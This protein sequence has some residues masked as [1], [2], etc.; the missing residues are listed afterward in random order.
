MIAN[1]RS[2]VRPIVLFAGVL[3]LC[4]HLAQAD[5]PMVDYAVNGG[6]ER[7]TSVST[8]CREQFA[9]RSVTVGEMLPQSWQLL[10]G[11]TKDADV[12]LVEGKDAH[13][14][15]RA[16]R[17][18]RGGAAPRIGSFGLL[19][20]S[21]LRLSFWISGEGGA[22]VAVGEHYRVGSKTR[23]SVLSAPKKPGRTDW[24]QVQGTVTLNP[25][26]RTFS[27]TFH[28][29]GDVIVDDI[30]LFAPAGTLTPSPV[31]DH[32]AKSDE[33]TLF[34]LDFDDGLPADVKVA[35][36]PETVP[37]R[38]RKAMH[39]PAESALHVS[40]KG[41]IGRQQGTVECWVKP[42]FEGNDR[43]D[44]SFL[45]FGRMT[46][47]L[48]RRTKYNHVLFFG[49][50]HWQT[51][52]AVMSPFWQYAA[53]WG[54]GQWHHVAATWSDQTWQLFV[55]GILVSIAPKIPEERKVKVNTSY[56]K[57][58]PP[59]FDTDLVIGSEGLALD[60]IRVSDV[61]RYGFPP[62]AAQTTAAGTALKAVNEEGEPDL[63]PWQPDL[64]RG[65]AAAV[66][67]NLDWVFEDADSDASAEERLPDGRPLLRLRDATDM[68]AWQA[69]DIDSGKYILGIITD[70]PGQV[71]LN[72]VPIPF[73]SG[74][75]A[76]LVANGDAV[77]EWRTATALD[78]HPADEL[79]FNGK[80]VLV[81]VNLY[82]NAPPRGICNANRRRSHVPD[83]FRLTATVESKDGR[84]TGE[85]SVRNLIG[86][87]TDAAIHARLVDYEQRTLRE[88]TQTVPLRNHASCR[89][90]FAE[91]PTGA[92]L[93][94]LY[95]EVTGP[96]GAYQRHVA[97]CLADVPDGSRPLQ[98]LNGAWPL[99]C[100]KGNPKRLDY[101]AERVP[102][103]RSA[104][105]PG[106]WL[107]KQENSQRVG[108]YRRLFSIPEAMSGGR[109][110]LRFESVNF[111]AHVYVNGQ[112]VG[113][114]TGAWVPFEADIT[115]A[116]V[117]GDNVLEVGVRDVIAAMPP[118]L[119]A[120]MK[121]FDSVDH[122]RLDWPAGTWSPAHRN[123]AGISGFVS[124]QGRSPT[125]TRDI[126]VLSSFGQKRLTVRLTVRNT[127]GAR[128]LIVWQTVEHDGREVLRLPQAD[129]SCPPNGDTRLET[130]CAW[131]E[132]VLWQM[133]QPRLCVLVTQLREHGRVVDEARTRFGF[134][135][136]WVD[137]ARL[138]L[139]GTPQKLRFAHTVSTW[140][141][142][143]TFR[144][145]Y[146]GIGTYPI[147]CLDV[148]KHYGNANAYRLDPLQIALDFG[149]EIG[150]VT[151]CRTTNVWKTAAGKLLNDTYW[152]NA[153][154]NAREAVRAHGNHP[155]VAFW[156][157]SNEF[158]CFSR[159]TDLKDGEALAVRRL[160]RL[161]AVVHEERP[162]SLVESDS[163]GDLHGHADIWSLHYPLDHFPD[164]KMDGH[165]YVFPDCSY[166][167]PLS[168]MFEPEEIIP[169]GDRT[170]AQCP[171]RY[172]Y[173]NI[174]YGLKPIGA[175]ETCWTHQWK[176]A[177]GSC[178]VGGE[179]VFEDDV[180]CRRF[181]FNPATTFQMEGYRDLEMVY[182]YPWRHYFGWVTHQSIPP[183]AA[184]MPFKDTAFIS[185]SPAT[186]TF[187][188]HND[189]ET[190]RVLT[191][192]VAFQTA[193]GEHQM[194][195]VSRRV[196]PAG[197]V[198]L[199]LTPKVPEVERMTRGMLSICM[200]EGTKTH[201]ME[202]VPATVWPSLPQVDRKLNHT[203]LFDPGG[204][205][206]PAL[207][208]VS[209]DLSSCPGLPP[210]N[211]RGLV[212]APQ[213]LPAFLNAVSVT[214]LKRRVEAGLKVVI[215]RHNKYPR[216]LLPVDATPETIRWSGITFA[217]ALGHP[218]LNGV[219][220]DDLR[221]WGR[222]HIVSKADLSLPEKGSFRVIVD[223][224]SGSGLDRAPL[225]EAYLGA[226][227]FVLCQMLLIEKA[228]SHPVAARL[229][230]NLLAY[231]NS[232]AVSQR[233]TPCAVL[234]PGGSQLAEHLVA[235]GVKAE[236]LVWQ[237]PVADLPA[238]V[239]VDAGFPLPGAWQTRIAA[240]LR[241]GGTILASRVTPDTK[242]DWEA[243]SGHALA[244]NTRN[245]EEYHG[246]AVK[247]RA[248]ASLLQ[249][250][251]NW[252]LCWR[253]AIKTAGSVF[254]ASSGTILA[255]LKWACRPAEPHLDS[256]VLLEPAALVDLPCSKGRLVI[257][258]LQWMANAGAA[259]ELANRLASM[260]L[261]N[262][263]V[264]IPPASPI[265]KMPDKVR[266]KPLS[267]AEFANRSL[268]D[269]KER[270]GKGGWSDQGAKFDMRY[271][272]TGRMVTKGVPFDIAPHPHCCV[273]LRTDEYPKE[274]VIGLDCAVA[275]ICLLHSGAWYGGRLHLASFLMEYVDGKSLEV[276]IVGERNVR[277]WA[278]TDLGPLP[279]RRQRAW[280]GWSGR[281]DGF[282]NASVYVLE[283]VNPRPQAVLKAIRFVAHSG[284]V[285]I[286]LAVTL[287]L[288]PKA[289]EPALQPKYM[290]EN[291]RKRIAA[292][293]E[294][295]QTKS[296]GEA[297]ET[298]LADAP[299]KVDARKVLAQI[300][301]DAGELEK[302]R[303]Q[304]LQALK[305]SGESVEIL[306]LLGELNHGRKA[307]RKAL[308]FYRRS[309]A[310]EWNQPTTIRA[311]ETLEELLSNQDDE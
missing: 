179:R 142:L 19:K 41:R 217:R 195:R 43:K 223:S 286:L 135:D 232:A 99:A 125:Y 121:P 29:V 257:D 79:R 59:G 248:D 12:A 131:P 7:V 81:G 196:G 288:P 161:H 190:T 201:H 107:L 20:P 184:V 239:L 31:L 301:W 97:T 173:G 244:V 186:R 149:D 220:G 132:P 157:A 225:L 164:Q 287:A 194:A 9:E 30:Q 80:R 92:H 300:L 254:G 113:E 280:I 263:G 188:L 112:K 136:W 309:L 176:G 218:V 51:T 219:A 127:S 27:L 45:S 229:L 181:G 4:V 289:P 262:L 55:D 305:Y 168:R 224:G 2:Y 290:T 87:D 182:L 297:L 8:R 117:P 283:W 303:V 276:P 158:A 104:T 167:R 222:D 137:G 33:N 238:V 140:H 284:R 63:D 242:S 145:D 21:P 275:G 250:I 260:L 105:V 205:C 227:S 118:D 215:L 292:L 230:T 38:F 102:F 37:G 75:D 258:Q 208:G 147:V 14:G 17:V 198:R 73:D 3:P 281:S 302:A 172:G 261:T 255:P 278:S 61:V 183:I 47:F 153:E 178:T 163:D 57:S 90:T 143:N 116:A 28:L 82:R 245:V 247:R 274:A 174:P 234:A 253:R 26:T 180:A 169:V 193:A 269:E 71:F 68:A 111:E 67:A 24:E 291:E 42:D 152:K 170:A 84:I 252:V 185:G 249:G 23:H 199:E 44:H 162:G 46:G 166:W 78:L 141:Y 64:P 34:L 101:A 272:P 235:L 15:N 93:Y 18:K 285:P 110:L 151:R 294:A 216:N 298:L 62:S 265:L 133:E 119:V 91:A 1:M 279:A 96:D 144:L 89:D 177:H 6:F 241:D 129:L 10:P 299:D 77:R 233:F 22:S 192:R 246:R 211:A 240:H 165:S 32:P 74:G 109:V 98:W 156:E 264:Y 85:F 270:D 54:P 148:A 70:Q 282:P 221:F 154:G 296:A 124:L 266:Y 13:S 139:N 231:A 271:L 259:S 126:R 310:A 203:Y 94:R 72:G 311:I 100:Q 226:G 307:Y 306:N 277:D 120:K 189:T 268:V 39:F 130:D 146:R 200:Q 35:G 16:L 88:W 204:V 206:A 251:S 273:V 60:D 108:W 36:N 65:D 171:S 76:Y 122:N 5:A 197:L 150:V 159:Y 115:E 52:G 106:Y 236:P 69:R 293:V 50:S 256:R 212:I 243:I 308:A 207:R 114:H 66:D 86:R 202:N 11:F 58:L 160:A 134:A 228:S 155:S 295:N 40:L 49:R 103:K 209:A 123:K 53:N 210:K 214:A 48:L 25:S 187:N 128:D 237:S 83:Y 213:A 175:G 95:L 304:Y 138:M 191:L 56:W 267:I